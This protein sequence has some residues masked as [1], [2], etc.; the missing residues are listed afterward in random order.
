[1]PPLQGLFPPQ[2]SNLALLRYRQSLYC[3]SHK[4]SQ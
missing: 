3:L 2:G 1:M 4:E